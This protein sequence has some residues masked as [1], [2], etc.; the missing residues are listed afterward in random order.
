MKIKTIIVEDLK[1]V[2]EALIN[3]LKQKC[4]QIE[5]LGEASS[6]EEGEQLIK[7]LKPDLIFLDIEIQ[8]KTGFDM[9]NNIQKALG[10]IDFRIIFMTAHREY[11]YVTRAIEYSAL[12]FINKPVDINKLLKAVKKAENKLVSDKAI[13]QKQLENLFDFLDNKSLSNKMVIHLAK[14]VL[15]YLD[16]DEINYISAEKSITKFHLIDGQVLTAMKNL[17]HYSKL[18]VQD[19]NFYPIS[20]SI[21]IN[22]AQ[23]KKHK[24]SKFQ[25]MLANGEVLLGSRR[26][27]KNLK[28]FLRTNPVSS[29]K[30]KVMQFLSNLISK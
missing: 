12:D 25:V 1:E 5:I 17:G 11:D 7:N 13:Y 19:F 3:L 2:R 18:I 22:L 29:T 8:N 16:I 28:D 14:G 24:P 21:I 27:S 9:L 6:I 15:E 4:P 30:N 10:S 20:K 26:G 23:L